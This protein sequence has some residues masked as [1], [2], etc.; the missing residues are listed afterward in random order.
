MQLLRAVS[1]RR[2]FGGR[3]R[4]VAI[5]ERRLAPLARG[6]TSRSGAGKND[7]FFVRRPGGQLSV[8]DEPDGVV[9]EQSIGLRTF[10]CGFQVR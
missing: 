7:V 6:S 2:A 3:P 5:V 1:D 9:M 4:D 8:V 10:A